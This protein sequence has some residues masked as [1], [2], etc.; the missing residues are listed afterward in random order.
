MHPNRSLGS[1]DGPPTPS[2]RRIG[3][4]ALLAL[5]LVILTALVL[6]L[7]YGNAP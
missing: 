5:G 7:I 1:A 4:L 6:F 2:W 3:L